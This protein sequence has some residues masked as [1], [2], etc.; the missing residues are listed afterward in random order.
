MW[1]KWKYELFKK[2]WI[3]Y[4]VFFIYIIC[5]FRLFL[6]WMIINNLIGKLFLGVYKTIE[7]TK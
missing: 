7:L 4:N 6:I 2:L 5:L 1:I 3:E